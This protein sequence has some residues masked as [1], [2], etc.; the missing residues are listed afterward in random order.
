MALSGFRTTPRSAMTPAKRGKQSRTWTRMQLRKQFSG[1][2]RTRPTTSECLRS[3]SSGPGPTSASRPPPSTTWKR[4]IRPTSCCRSRTG[5]RSTWSR[6]SVGASIKVLL[7]KI[8]MRKVLRLKNP[9]TPGYIRLNLTIYQELCLLCPTLATGRQDLSEP[10]FFC[11]G[12]F[13]SGL[14]D[15]AWCVISSLLV[16]KNDGNEKRFILSEQN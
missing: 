13:L 3:T 16:F 9:R 7:R 12:L 15:G 5:P 8:Q 10:F 2:G 1:S 11:L 14:F 4:S 6:F